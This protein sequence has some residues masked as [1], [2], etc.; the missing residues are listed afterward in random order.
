[1]KELTMK[2]IYYLTT[3]NQIIYLQNKRFEKL[4]AD[5]DATLAR[6]SKTL[7]HAKSI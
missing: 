6:S 4:L 3:V 7:A 1:M 2:D 5:A